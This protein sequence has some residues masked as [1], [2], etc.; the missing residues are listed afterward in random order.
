MITLSDGRNT[1][2]QWDIG[3]TLTVDD[4]CDEVHFSNHETRPPLTVMVK[5]GVVEIPNILLTTGEPLLC[6]FFV[7]EKDGAYT[8]TRKTFNVR[9][10]PKPSDYVYEETEVKTIESVVKNALSEAKESGDFDGR[11]A[12]EI[13]QDGGYTGTE[14]EF[15][16]EIS[17]IGHT[18]DALDAIL[19]IQDELLDDYEG[20]GKDWLARYNYRI[21]ELSAGFVNFNFD[22]DRESDT[23]T[24][25]RLFFE[26]RGG[27]TANAD[28]HTTFDI[29]AFEC[30]VISPKTTKIDE[31][32]GCEYLEV[33]DGNNVLKYALVPPS[34]TYIADWGFGD[35][36]PEIIDLTTFTGDLPFPTLQGTNS[37]AAVDTKILVPMGRKAEIES[38][39]GWCLLNIEEVDVW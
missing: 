16:E 8:E 21:Q 30:F 28:G 20:G 27:F 6:W 36:S 22:R 38:M 10:R 17:T 14:E 34:V 12:F 7:I 13:A 35:Y 9:K 3:R 33:S 29:S 11:S 19:D 24:P 26:P 15:A 1:L 31:H 23:T 18:D 2:Y 32:L 5:D 4:K 39:T 25:F 37:F